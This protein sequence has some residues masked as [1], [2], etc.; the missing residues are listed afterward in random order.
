MMV[1]EAAATTAPRAA[2]AT[3][4]YD[5]G[6]GYKFQIRGGKLMLTKR[7]ANAK[8]GPTAGLPKQIP[9]RILSKTVNNLL[10]RHPG[11]PALQSLLTA[12]AGPGSGTVVPAAPGPVT[13]GLVLGRKTSQYYP[14]SAEQLRTSRGNFEHP[15]PAG[16]EHCS[17][18][19]ASFVGTQGNAWHALRD[20]TLKYSAFNNLSAYKQKA[21]DLFNRMN[22]VARLNATSATRFNNDVK[23][24]VAPLLPNPMSLKNYMKIGDV[25]GIYN[26]DSEHHG[27]AFYEGASGWSFSYNTQPVSTAVQTTDGKKWDN[28]MIG[29]ASLR[30]KIIEP[31]GMNT[32]LGFVGGMLDGE[33]VIFHNV[34]GTVRVDTLSAIKNR[35]MYPVWVEDGGGTGAG[36]PAS[37]AP[38]LSPTMPDLM[39]AA[40]SVKRKISSY[41]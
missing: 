40:R 6:A 24:I 17:K 33:P 23:Q 12:S 2:P 5:D 30:F 15:T 9:G 22:K 21:E 29:N 35:N 36:V 10:L 4:T 25:V 41:F 26:R 34:G 3:V 14:V 38:N 13:P 32:H 16:T 37:S 8:Q 27:E 28:S 11:D 31:F 19:A 20:G 7:P 39:G 18:W 1:D